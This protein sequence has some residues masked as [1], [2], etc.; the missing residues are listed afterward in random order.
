MADD[1]KIALTAPGSTAVLTTRDPKQADNLVAQGWTRADENTPAT[2]PATPKAPTAKRAPA[3]KK[4][5]APKSESV[6]VTTDD[7]E[8]DDG[9]APALND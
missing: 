5:A 6:A 4:A 1:A 2:K 9:S 3:A 8:P 7:T